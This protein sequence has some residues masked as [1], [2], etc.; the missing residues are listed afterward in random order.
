M[1]L[2]NTHNHFIAY[3]ISIVINQIMS[4]VNLEEFLSLK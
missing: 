2:Y 1:N 3:C 4:C